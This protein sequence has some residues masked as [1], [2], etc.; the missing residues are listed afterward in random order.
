[1]KN[2]NI[3]TIV[4][5]KETDFASKIKTTIIKNKLGFKDTI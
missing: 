4:F 1:M 5:N 3:C 2:K